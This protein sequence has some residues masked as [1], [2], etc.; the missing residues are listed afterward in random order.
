MSKLRRHLGTEVPSDLVP[1]KF[2]GDEA[3]DGSSGD[4]G[5]LPTVPITAERVS[6]D[7]DLEKR[8]DEYSCGWLREKKGKRW[9]EENYDAVIQSLREL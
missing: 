8:S 3:P 4:Q 9:V 6:T 7:T 1:P 2:D 5:D